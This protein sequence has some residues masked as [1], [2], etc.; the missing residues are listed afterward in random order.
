MLTFGTQLSPLLAS[1][2]TVLNHKGCLKMLDLKRMAPKVLRLRIRG[3]FNIGKET[4][5]SEVYVHLQN[6]LRVYCPVHAGVEGNGRADRLAGKATLTSGLLLGRSEV[7]K[8]LR[9]L[10]A[11][12]KPRTPH[13]R[14]SG[15]ERCG[16]RKHS[17]NVL[18]RTRECHRQSNEHWNSFKGNVGETVLRDRVERIWAFPSA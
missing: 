5:A 9:Q 10:P 6:L 14:S 16:K 2:N 15:G 4:Q 8:N 17:T 1:T 7:L 13:H 11:G 12:T 18:E 3:N